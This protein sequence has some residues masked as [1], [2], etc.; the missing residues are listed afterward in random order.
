MEKTIHDTDW[1]I[2]YIED[3][4][5]SGLSLIDYCK[6][7]GFSYSAMYWHIRKV[8]T[9][10]DSESVEIIPVNVTGTDIIQSDDISIY[11]NGIR[12]SG[13]ID[14]IRKILGVAI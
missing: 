9:G 14:T 6:G 4:K 13:N 2:P 11:I 1:W 7:H 12:I 8:K 3:Y 10:I 5:S